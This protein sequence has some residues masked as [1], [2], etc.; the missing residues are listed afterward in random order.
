MIGHNGDKEYT[1]LIEPPIPF[2]PKKKLQNVGDF[3]DCKEGFV[4]FYNITAQTHL[5]S[6][7]KCLFTEELSPY[8]S[9]CLKEYGVNTD[10]SC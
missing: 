2:T 6:F 7:T 3:V 9:V 5:Y 4:L 1:A 10:L 8:F